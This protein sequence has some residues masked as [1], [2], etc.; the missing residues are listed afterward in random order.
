[1]LMSENRDIIDENE[2][3][4]QNENCLQLA[5]SRVKME[6]SEVKMNFLSEMKSALKKEI[7]KL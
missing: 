5:C 6:K 2:L 4:F 1:M 7:E 3:S